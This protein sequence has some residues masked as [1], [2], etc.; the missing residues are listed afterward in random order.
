MTV[1]GTH[2]IQKCRHGVVVAQCRCPSPDKLV[3]LIDCPPE[4]LQL[5][6]DRFE[7]TLTCHICG[8]KFATPYAFNLHMDCHAED[9]GTSEA[10]RHHNEQIDPRGL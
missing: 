7:L 4:C 10:M 8:H 6:G 5:F 9:D 3:H 2:F 1:A